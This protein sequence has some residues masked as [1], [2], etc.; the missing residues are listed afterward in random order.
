MESYRTLSDEAE[1][2]S[3]NAQQSMGEV[4][5]VRLE[6]SAMNQEKQHLSELVQQQASE[7]QQHLTSLNSYE[8][9]F[10]KLTQ[11]LS[12]MEGTV[13]Q[14]QEEKKA[15]LA[16]VAAT[17]ELCLQLD[18]TKESLSRQLASQTISYEQVQSQLEDFRV[19]RDFLK[20]QLAAEHTTVENLQ[21]LLT[22]ERKKEFT[23]HLSGQEKDIELQRL[24]QQLIKLEAER[25]SLSEQL[26][27]LR[28]Q[29]SGKEEELE[30][31][32]SALTAERFQK[33]HIKQDMHRLQTT[34]GSQAGQ[35]STRADSHTN[36]GSMQE[37]EG[38][39]IARER[40]ALANES[41]KIV[42]ELSSSPLSGSSRNTSSNSIR[43]S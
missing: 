31:T 21:T 26:L 30:R 34:V 6:L 1:R 27:K 33:E 3:S 17:R 40:A 8:L 39:I 9:H 28:G 16:D 19:E 24:R 20:Q 18:R 13:R 15:L 38:E 5:G 42:A 35:G 36:G 25:L 22:N 41:A 10:S 23:S 29:F 12:K 14:E 43:H 32:K 2:L 11:A 37:Q 7:I 4:S